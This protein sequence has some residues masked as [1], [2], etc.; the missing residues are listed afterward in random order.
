MATT[1]QYALQVWQAQRTVC[2][3]LGFDIRTADLPYRAVMVSTCVMIAC[4]L[5]ILFLKNTATDT[6]MQT[7]FTNARD[8]DYPVLD[9]FPP[10][11][12]EDNIDPADPNLGA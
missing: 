3:K 7:V 8:A 1:K 9:P 11:I 2:G 4:V 10:R 12:T 5:R 6:E